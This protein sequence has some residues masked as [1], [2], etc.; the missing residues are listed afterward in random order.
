M[1]IALLTSDNIDGLIV[2]H[3]L[4]VDKIDLQAIVYEKK[5]V[6]VKAFVKRCVY[7]FLGRIGNIVFFGYNK[8]KIQ[9]VGNINSEETMAVLREIRPDLIIVVGTRKLEPAIFN[10]PKYGTINLHSGILPYY[11]GADS[12]FWAMYN[13]EIDKIG[14]T[15]H[16]LD[17]ELDSGDIILTE[18]QKVLAVDKHNNLRMKNLIV[19]AAKISEAVRKI[20]KNEITRYKQDTSLAVTYKTV[21]SKEIAGFYA[22]KRSF[23]KSRVSV[24]KSFGPEGMTV[25]ENVAKRPSLLLEKPGD[26]RESGIFCLRID[27]DEYSENNFRSYYPVFKRYN[28]ATSIFFSINSF[29]EAKGAI[30]DC[31]TMGVDI[32]SHGFYHHT[33]NDYESNRYNLI[34]AREFLEGLGIDAKGFVSPMGKWNRDL[35][36]ALE[37]EKFKYSS[38]FAYDYAGFPSYPIIDGRYSDVL[39]IPVF[40]VAPELFFEKGYAPGKIIEYYKEAID[41]MRANGVPVIIY[42]HTNPKFQQV[43][44]LLARICEY[45]VDRSGLEPISMTGFFEKWTKTNETFRIRRTPVS[46]VVNEMFVGA[47]LRE[48]ASERVKKEVKIFLDYE[49]ITPPEELR[50]GKLKKMLKLSARRFFKYN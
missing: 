43:P 4:F 16:Y 23:E 18:K 11:R 20:E 25:S 35:A 2:S 32:G 31:K 36:K 7:L 44:D 46:R 37:D 12:E 3:R 38:E 48:K 5:K 17:K 30:I 40:P 50:C 15:V 42:A 49:I 13:G 14:V 9:S 29:K 21:T 39:Q 8:I 41:M 22:Y 33:Y 6:T 34:R 1:K 45:A 27:A 10:F 19:G 24:K 26:V 28:K 47:E